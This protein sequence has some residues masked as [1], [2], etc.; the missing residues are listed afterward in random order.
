LDW[1]LNADVS[2]R[3]AHADGNGILECAE[4]IALHSFIL[5]SVSLPRILI[6]SCQPLTSLSSVSLPLLPSLPSSF[7]FFYHSFFASPSVTSILLPTRLHLFLLTSLSPPTP[8]VPVFRPCFYLLISLFLSL[9]FPLHL[10]HFECPSFPPVC[11]LLCDPYQHLFFLL[12]IP[13]SL[14]SFTPPAIIH[15][16]LIILNV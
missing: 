1:I 4:F 7:F 12:S 6:S 13:A 9:S 10:S 3:S 14:F 15:L 5:Y 2:D 8:P 11:L 16:S